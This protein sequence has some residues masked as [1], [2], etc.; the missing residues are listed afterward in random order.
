MQNTSVQL[1]TGS[2]K[3]SAKTTAKTGVSKATQPDTAMTDPFLQ[4]IMSMIG[5]SSEPTQATGTEDMSGLSDVFGLVRNINTAS[6][7]ADSN[8]SNTPNVLLSLLGGSSNSY[9]ALESLGADGTDTSPTLV[10]QLLQM[11]NQPSDATAIRDLTA[12]DQT[13]ENSV[14]TLLRQFA[15]VPQNGVETQLSNLL[16]KAQTATETDIDAATASAL[17]KLPA[18]E[19]AVTT[20]TTATADESD[21]G[22]L[23]RQDFSRTITKARELLANAKPDPDTDETQSADKLQNAD[24]TQSAD[25]LQSTIHAS[26][27]ATP[28]ELRFQNAVAKAESTPLPQ[29]V[30]DGLQSNLSLGKSEF[31]IKLKPEALGE[32]TV[33]LTEE[34]GKTTLTIITASAATARLLNSDMDSL[35]AAMAPMNVRVNEAVSQTAASQQGSL[36]QFD[37]AGRQFA[38]QQQQQQ[39][40]QQFAQRHNAVHYATGRTAADE[41][42]YAA[43]AVQTLPPS[44]I[45]RGLNTYV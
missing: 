30:K 41:N 6:L 19:S 38:G 14:Q 42:L 13:G 23:S 5:Q 7:L 31:T 24:E 43:A 4:I 27:T 29:Q 35:K 26:K 25:K 12:I 37:M 32:I 21:S 36:Q 33:K 28:F 18:V 40:A 45:G 2:V 15:E 22:L 20:L 39:F 3:S 9:A 44:Y 1:Q 16:S 10:S 11:L 17:T 34:A 8:S